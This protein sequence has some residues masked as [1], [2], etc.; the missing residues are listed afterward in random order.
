MTPLAKFKLGLDFDNTIVCYDAAIEKLAEDLF[1]LPLDVPRTKLGLRE[2]LRGADREPE[3]TAFQGELYG[4]GM[5]HAQPFE[6]VIET[7]LKLVAAGHHLVIVSHRSRRP[8]AGKLHDLHAAARCWV[9]EWLQ[10]VGLFGQ[11]GDESDVHFLETF[12]QKLAKIAELNCNA[13]LDDLPEVFAA[14][15]FPIGVH[16]ILFDATGSAKGV[17]DCSISAVR[18]WADI[19]SMLSSL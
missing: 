4:P 6:G 16:A 10:S 18:S 19:P 15:G 17:R 9:A 3:W 7:M 5:R 13:F 11:L 14:S 8:Y 2:Y 12:D 1:D